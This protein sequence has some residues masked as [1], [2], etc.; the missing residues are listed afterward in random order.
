MGATAINKS[1]RA[2]LVVR[3]YMTAA[4]G[5]NLIGTIYH[6]E[7]FTW[8]TTYVIPFSDGSV[9]RGIYFKGTDGMKYGWLLD[10]GANECVSFLNYSFGNVVGPDGDTYK[11]FK[12]RTATSRYDES[13]TYKGTTVVGGRILTNDTEPGQSMSYCMR[14]MY[15]ET[16]AGTGVFRP[17][18]GTNGE[19]GFVDTGI[20]NGSDAARIGIYGNW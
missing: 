4:T 1:G 17:I 5:D 19:Y 20:R 11:S 15:Y 9:Y 13:G 8:D 12:V 6:N 2:L 7:C 14:A 16:G 18:S 10:S 3:E